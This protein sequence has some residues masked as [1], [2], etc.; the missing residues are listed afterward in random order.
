MVSITSSPLPP[1][2]SF[3]LVIVFVTGERDLLSE[4]GFRG[5][6]SLDSL[7]RMLSSFFRA[8]LSITTDNN[9]LDTNFLIMNA[10]VRRNGV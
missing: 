6:F 7:A 2:S 9:A 10:P 5:A 3:L 4:E 1:L 8:S